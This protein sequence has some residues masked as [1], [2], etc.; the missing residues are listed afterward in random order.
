M[1]GQLEIF[2][3]KKLIANFN[4]LKDKVQRSLYAIL[5]SGANVI[6]NQAKENAPYVTGNL[7][8]SLHSE[9]FQEEKGGATIMIGTDVEY[10]RAMEFGGS[11]Q[12]P[13]GYLRKAMDERR[14]DAINKMADA[15]KILMP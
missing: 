4:E 11:T 15:V 2:G 14:N 7:R 13:E 6:V 10:A 9:G 1:S 3:E 12:K 8:R 5:R